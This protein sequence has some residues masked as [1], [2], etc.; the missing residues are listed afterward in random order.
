[1]TIPLPHNIS[2]MGFAPSLADQS[3]NFREQI[4]QHLDQQPFFGTDT[5][6]GVENEFQVAV[7][8][9]KDEV[10]L[11][12]TIIDS[13]YYKNLTRRAGRGDLSPHVLNDLDAFLNEQQD[14]TWENSW[15]RFPK[16][17]LG[18]YATSILAHDLLADKAHPQGPVRQDAA[19]FLLFSRQGEAW[20]RVPVSYLLKLSLADAIGQQPDADPILKRTGERLMDHLISDNRG[21]AL[22][23][24]PLLILGLQLL[25]VTLFFIFGRSMVTTAS[26]S[27][28]VRQDRI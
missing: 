14:Q 23:F 2:P 10:D 18:A 8:G 20:L 11:A 1:M 26:L 27:F 3:R 17:L 16:G 21:L 13:N 28:A 5:T 24:N 9:N 6:V 15:V 25:W 22:L 12:L 7:E 19:L 4:L